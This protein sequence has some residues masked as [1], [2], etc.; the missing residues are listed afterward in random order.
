MLSRSEAKS[1]AASSEQEAYAG[2]VAAFEAGEHDKGLRLLE[3]FVASKPQNYRFWH[4]RGLLQRA[5]GR[6]EEAL[7]S[8]HHAVSLDAAAAKPAAKATPKATTKK[9]TAQ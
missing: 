5:L 7:D 3:P 4:L 6:R 2:A 9:A 8:L 1:L